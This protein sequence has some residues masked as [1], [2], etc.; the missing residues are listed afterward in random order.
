MNVTDRTPMVE[1]FDAQVDHDHVGHDP[2][3]FIE[4][5]AR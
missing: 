1:P 3:A 5:L 4:A 2:R